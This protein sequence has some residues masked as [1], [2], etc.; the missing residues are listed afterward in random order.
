[1]LGTALWAYV[2]GGLAPA[3]QPA[4]AFHLV[5]VFTTIGVRGQESLCSPHSAVRIQLGY[6]CAFLLS[7]CAGRAVPA[8][9][10]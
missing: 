8:L 9:C 7:L 3:F 4:T 10:F 1:M 2:A 5:A 6:P